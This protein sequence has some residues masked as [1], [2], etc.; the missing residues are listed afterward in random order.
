MQKNNDVRLLFATRIAR[1][2]AYGFLSVVL[3]LYLA[4]LGLTENRIGLLLTLTLVGDTIISLGITT[5][6]DRIGR[7]GMLIVGAV[8]VAFAGILF[9]STTNFVLLLIAASLA[10]SR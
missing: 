10:A 9:A 3:L 7:K 5:T 8:L 6:A 4:E 1:M 2:F